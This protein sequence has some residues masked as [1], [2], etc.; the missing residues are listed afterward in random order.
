MGLNYWPII[1]SPS[2]LG[3]IKA[4]R[5]EFLET[6]HLPKLLPD[7]SLI[8]LLKTFRMTWP[9]YY[10]VCSANSSETLNRARTRASTAPFPFCC[11]R[12]DAKLTGSAHPGSLYSLRRPSHR[13]AFYFQIVFGDGATS[14]IL[15]RLGYPISAFPPKPRASPHLQAPEPHI[16]A[17]NLERYKVE[18]PPP[19]C[20]LSFHVSRVR[21]PHFTN[22][23]F[24]R[25]QHVWLPAP[26]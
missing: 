2:I 6:S 8:C 10:G 13:Y 21:K 4:P 1:P 7:I 23:S 15:G 17:S 14:Q 25:H 11:L 12:H 24:L 26:S 16:L 18:T 22:R 19:L 3:T 9:G 5:N 20:H